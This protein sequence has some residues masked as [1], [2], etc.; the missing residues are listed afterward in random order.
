MLCVNKLYG[1][2]QI[3]EWVE[4][5][6]GCVENLASQR[7]SKYGRLNNERSSSLTHTPYTNTDTDSSWI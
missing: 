4:C 3:N 5:R 6:T 1:G 7:H 2:V